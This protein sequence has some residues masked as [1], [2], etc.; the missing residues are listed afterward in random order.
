MNRLL[1]ALFVASLAT[2]VVM[3]Q[4]T[5]PAG[6]NPAALL[7]NT[8]WKLVAVGNVPAIALPAAREASFMLHSGD[9]RLSGSGGCNRL[10]GKYELDADTLKLAPTGT[11]MMACPEALMQQ[12]S[13]FVSALKMTTSYKVS[14]DTLELRNGDRVLA[15][16]T[17]QSIR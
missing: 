4:G 10:L 2:D 8:S 13:D 6:A 14:G 1:L 9:H 17:A 5:A 7:E 12:E 3:A 16:F 15:R 11:T